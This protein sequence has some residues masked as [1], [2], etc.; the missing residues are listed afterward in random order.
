MFLTKI[1][2]S[3]PFSIL[4][5]SF[6][7]ANFKRASFQLDCGIHNFTMDLLGK[8][9]TQIQSKKSFAVNICFCT[10]VQGGVFFQFICACAANKDFLSSGIGLYT[11][12]FN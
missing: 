10:F 12:L 2:C 8:L 5:L 11:D 3:N 9:Q 4:Q 6:D 7:D 1:S